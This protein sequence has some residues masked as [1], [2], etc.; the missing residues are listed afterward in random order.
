MA[1]KRAFI[2]DSVNE[3]VKKVFSNSSKNT[4]YHISVKQ[5]SELRE[6]SELI[7]NRINM[8]S[9]KLN[10]DELEKVMEHLLDVVTFLSNRYTD[11][12]GK[13]RD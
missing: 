7:M 2:N 6:R 13:H 1:K 5:V 9:E 10:P 4:P 12:L 3:A 8:L 11:I